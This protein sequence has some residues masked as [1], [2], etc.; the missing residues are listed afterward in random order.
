MRRRHFCQR[1]SWPSMVKLA[2][3]GWVMSIGLT[4]SRSALNAGTLP[5]RVMS[6]GV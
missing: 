2:P 5:S 4:S 3:S 6:S 1:T